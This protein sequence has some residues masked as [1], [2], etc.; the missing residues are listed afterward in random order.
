M[1]NAP[2]GGLRYLVRVRE[3]GVRLRQH[4]G[5]PRENV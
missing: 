5:H 3:C 1:K 2:S 4:S